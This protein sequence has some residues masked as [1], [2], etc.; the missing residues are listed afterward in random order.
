[1][2]GTIKERKSSPKGRR[3]DKKQRDAGLKRN[4]E[5]RPK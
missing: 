4:G 2:S 3:V 5:K 1:M